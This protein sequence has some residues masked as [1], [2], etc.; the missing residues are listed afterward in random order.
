M[1]ARRDYLLIAVYALRILLCLA[2]EHGYIQPDEFFQFTEPIAERLLGVKAYIPWEFSEAH[3]IRSVFLPLLIAGSSFKAIAATNLA[4][5]WLLLVIPRLVITLL[6][7]VSDYCLYQ[8]CNLLDKHA[9]RNAQIVFATSYLVLTYC[10]HTFTNSIE[11][12]LLS[13]L[14]LFTAKC[15]KSGK[16]QHSSAIATITCIGLFNR[17][18]FICFAVVPIIFWILSDGKKLAVLKVLRI[19]ITLLPAFTTTAFTF[20]FVDTLYYSRISLTDLN[21]YQELLKRIV[22]TPLNFIMYNTKHSNLEKHGLHPFYQHSVVNVPLAFTVLGILAYKETIGVLWCT[23]MRK[24]TKEFSSEIRRLMLLTFII[25]L[26]LLSFIPHQEPRFLIPCLLP[27]C[28]LFGKKVYESK[29]H[30]FLW[31]VSNCV[32][33]LIY[34]FVHQAGVTKALFEVRQQFDNH[35]GQRMDVI[36]SRMYLP[37]QHLLH[38]SQK[39]ENLHIHDLSIQEFPEAVYN[40]LKQLNETITENIY[41]VIPSCLTIRLETVFHNLNIHNF[42]LEKQ[43]FPHFTFEDLQA[44]FELLMLKQRSPFASAFSMNIFNVKMRD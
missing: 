27:L 13:L 34:G 18:T 12:V 21:E 40:K 30:F 28:F 39:N 26:S 9:A 2:P 36:F 10:T 14:L 7:F 11:L 43:I 5:S 1:F 24:K 4:S 20:V 19:L 31:I 15:V 44:S 35:A 33:V 23:V 37:P 41:V 8:I 6:S 32:L 29:I 16:T 22:I 25:S 42:K 17:A 3:P 38:I